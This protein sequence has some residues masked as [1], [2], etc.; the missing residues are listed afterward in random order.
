MICT[1][2]PT[3]VSIVHHYHVQRNYLLFNYFV[4]LIFWCYFDLAYGHVR[5]AHVRSLWL[6]M[7]SKFKM[8]SKCYLLDPSKETA[9][10]DNKETSHIQ[11]KK[12]A[13]ETKTTFKNVC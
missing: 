12:V 3:T 4:A 2:F 6:Q 9:Y 8:N 10:I 7:F 1:I 5:M 11:L 13:K